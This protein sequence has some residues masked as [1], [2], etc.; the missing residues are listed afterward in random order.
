MKHPRDTRSRYETQHVNAS[1][2]QIL[3]LR[4]SVYTYTLYFFLED[5][6]A[7]VSTHGSKGLS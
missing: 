3:D 6:L 7:V 5:L 4:A 2:E 1:F